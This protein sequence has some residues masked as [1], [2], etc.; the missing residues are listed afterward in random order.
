[1][2]DDETRVSAAAANLMERGMMKVLAQV[3]KAVVSDH[4]PRVCGLKVRFSR[5]GDADV[6]WDIRAS[7]EK[8]AP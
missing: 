2:S 6:A 3:Q 8:P 4:P 7:P 5:E 1:M